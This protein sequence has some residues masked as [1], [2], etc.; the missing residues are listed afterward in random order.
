VGAPG[1]VF[2]ARSVLGVT[3]LRRGDATAAAARV[4]GLP[5][6]LPHL[7]ARYARGETILAAAE[8]G[9]ARDGAASVL[10]HVRQ[11][12]ADL[13]T[14]PGY[15][16]GDP[17][18]AAWLARTA[19][20]AGDEEAAARAASAAKALARDNPGYP[21][22]AAA[23]AH[24]LGLVTRSAVRIGEAAAQHSDPWAR[25]SAAEDLGVLYAAQAEQE[26]A[27]H[28]LTR[29]LR[30]YQTTGA[31]A[32]TARIRRRLRGLGV[33]RR[34]ASTG[35]RPASGWQ[36]LTDTERTVSEL[37]AQGLNNQQIADQLYISVHT[38]AFHMRQT[39]RKLGIGSRVELARIVMGRAQP[40]VP[41]P[42]MPG[43]L[44]TVLFG[45]TTISWPD[46]VA[47]RAGREADHGRKLVA[48]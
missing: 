31:A 27:I 21:A 33:R 40:V 47:E 23:A 43:D 2:V 32:D 48:D 17:A 7:A 19:L 1:Y 18:M 5:A 41:R 9:E 45:S 26:Q 38:V 30:G 44:R 8:I 13:G 29:A 42:T 37:A 3:A 6:P 10:G 4:A 46:D 14:R 20:A 11:V 22:V 24:S 12:C 28:H 25:A 35:D 39:F 16:L 34:R 36:S 15:L